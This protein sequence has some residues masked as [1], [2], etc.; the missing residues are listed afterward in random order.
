LSRLRQRAQSRKTEGKVG[1]NIIVQGGRG[2]LK[3]KEKRKS[4]GRGSV[5]KGE[6]GPLARKER[7]LSGSKKNGAKLEEG[8][9]RKKE[10]NYLKGGLGLAD[11]SAGTN[12]NKGK[13]GKRGAD[14]GH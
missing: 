5:V 3:A 6:A 12:S 9:V 1:G 14:Q 4:V 7:N 2:L 8:P 10:S 13:D 11:I